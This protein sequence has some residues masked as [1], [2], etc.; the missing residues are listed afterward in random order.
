MRTLFIA[1]LALALAP[2]ARAQDEEAVSGITTSAV[3]L[4]EAGTS[5]GQASAVSIGLRLGIRDVEGVS[6]V[7][8]VDVL[9]TPVV[10]EEL[11]M[12]FDELEPLADM[13][14]TGDAREAYRRADEIVALFE[15][16]LS[17]V[18]RARLVDAYM[19]SAIGRCRAGAGRDC[20]DRIRQII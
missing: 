6:F 4:R 18:P 20:D 16:N 5:A 2:I 1:A 13:V 19:L 8:P 15:Q 14:R 17:A 9:S 11:Q 7:H 3:L 12:T 10:S